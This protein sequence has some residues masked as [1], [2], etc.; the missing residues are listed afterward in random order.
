MVNGRREEVDRCRQEPN[1]WRRVV[2]RWKRKVN[3]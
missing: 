3:G 1:G 2:D